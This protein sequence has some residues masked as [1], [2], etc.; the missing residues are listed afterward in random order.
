MSSPE[1]TAIVCDGEPDTRSVVVRLAEDAGYE[2][3][4][5]VDTAPDAIALTRMLQPQLVVIDQDLPYLTGLAVLP[6]LKE[7]SPSTE[8]LLLTRDETLRDVAMEAGAF[9][10]VYRTRLSELSGALGRAR[11]FLE[12]ADERPAGE[13]RTGKDRR[14]HQDWNKVTSERRRGEDRRRS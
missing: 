4:G 13:R 3:V 9:G 8:V 7:A 5:A 1:L 2:V 11:E 14:Q 6:Q 12:T 10:V